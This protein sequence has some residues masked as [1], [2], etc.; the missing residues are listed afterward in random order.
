M[1]LLQ[2]F[3]LFVLAVALTT[4]FSVPVGAQLQTGSL[5]GTVADP[6]GGPLPG[7]TVTL[8]GGGAPQVQVTD[9]QGRFRFPGLP[10][11]EYNLESRLEGFSPVEYPGLVIS[12]GRNTE[13]QVVLSQAIAETLTVEGGEAPLLDE[14]RFSTGTAVPRAEL[15]Q[16]PTTRD[17]WSVLKTAP[18]VLMEK[19]NVG[20][21]L[22]GSQIRFVGPGAASGQTVWSMDGM[23]ITDMTA[24][25]TPPGYFDFEAF[26]EIQVTT[27]GND[28]SVATGGVVVNM[29]TRR[30]TNGWRGSGHYYFSDD[31]LVANS[32]VD[33]DD[34]GKAGPWNNNRAQP[35][36]TAGNRI[37]EVEDYGLELGGPIVRDHL[38]AWG[39]YSVPTVNLLTVGDHRDETQ[40][41][42]GNFKLNGQLG[43][44]N[45]ATFFVWDDEKFK[46]GKGGS[47]T[48]TP[49]ATQI[50]RREGDR[51]TAMKLED[52]HIFSPDFLASVLWSKVNGGFRLDPQGGAQIMYIDENGVTN[53]STFS[54]VAVRPQ[55]QIRGD[56]TYFFNTRDL[57]HE[58]KFGAGYREVEVDSS[59]SY[60]AGGWEFYGGYLTLTRPGVNRFKGEYKDVYVQ[61]TVTAGRFTANVGVRWD[62]QGGRTLPTTVPANP[63]APDLMPEVF[64]E[65]AEAGFEWSDIVPRLGITYALGENRSTLLRASYSQ[66][67]DQLDTG[68]GAWNNPVAYMQ[69]RIFYTSNNGDPTLTR[70][71]ILDEIA[72]PTSGFNPFTLE[73]V[74]SNSL[75][76]NLEA[77]RTD[78]ALL[79]VEHALRPNFV[80]G[81]RAH[82]RRLSGMLENERR[83]FDGDAYS[84]ENLTHLGRLHRRDDY[85]P[86]GSRTLTAPDG[87]QYTTTWYE[88][89]DGVTSRSGLHLE[90]GDREQDFKGVFLTA[91]KRLSEGW[92]LRANAGWQDWRWRIPDAENEDPTDKAP[93]G[94]RDGSPVLNGVGLGGNQAYF[95][96]SRWS[97]SITGLVQVARNRKWGFDLAG[98][99]GGRQG[100]PIQ[101]SVR[102]FLPESSEGRLGFVP[103]GSEV[104]DYRYPDTH[105]LDLR[106]AK[107]FNLQPTNLMLS[108]D[109]FNALNSGYVMLRANALGVSTGNWVRETMGPR[110]FRVGARLSLK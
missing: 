20:G 6:Q 68:A 58:L 3:R 60:A 42:A 4:A 110:T 26:E 109:C 46:R 21:N 72:S 96:N 1:R 104:G 55:E 23:V 63:V 64:Y 30:G 76:P 22:G 48:T 70:D 52:S 39:S 77:P 73:Y 18:G 101:Y 28:A 106:V 32:N 50:Q 40:L 95:L 45:S 14:R 93:G 62:Q 94:V 71:E 43:S 75:D 65:G 86:G 49:E 107:S 11:G 80:V 41:K 27:G 103:L 61:D 17:P 47:P 37:V 2:C 85:V 105:V 82:W 88:L 7:A 34:L 53:N 44:S 92:M 24:V 91:E 79:G 19:V 8:S 38:W 51:P 89:R 35:S 74:E 12:V 36:F 56:G 99:L 66:Y 13:I 84:P 5:F 97:Y 15:E 83:V 102:V 16:V 81:L 9:E 90:N 59:S 57:S 98:I 78:E 108:V 100:Y 29:V 33:Q 87:R 10:P 25:G 31:S 67:A 54:Y 69:Y